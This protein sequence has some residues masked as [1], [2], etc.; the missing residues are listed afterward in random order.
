MKKLLVLA[1]AILF[2]VAV[3]IIGTICSGGSLTVFGLGSGMLAVMPG[4]VTLDR[5]Y[6]Q[7]VKSTFGQGVPSPSFLRIE[8]TLANTKTRYK[9]DVKKSEATVATERTLDRN[10]VFVITH[11]GVYLI[12]QVSTTLGA[13]V[14]QTYPNTDIFVSA[15][16]FTPAHLELIYN[17]WLELKIGSKVN[18]E[19]M[20]MQKFRFVPTTQQHAA[21][22]Y[23]LNTEWNAEECSFWPGALIHLHGTQNIEVYIEFPSIASMQIAA[24]ASNTNNKLVFMP[25]GYL[26][27]NAAKP[28]GA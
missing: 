9:F 11:V 27:K 18:I 26:I 13:E 8:Q 10:D 12:A 7:Q 6:F 3:M 24:V 22:T 25:F 14:L 5:E 19:A 15:T 4:M 28:L 23:L 21:T 20:D 2:V 16:G 17:G 1:K